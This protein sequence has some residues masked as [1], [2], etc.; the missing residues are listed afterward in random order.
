M[1]QAVGK[2]RAVIQGPAQPVATLVLIHGIGLGPWFWEPWMEKLSERFRVLA[3]SLPGH[4]EPPEDAGLE[5]VIAGV[6]SVLS[7]LPE[8]PILVGH[9]MGAL[10]AQI[11][12]TRH[13]LRGLILMSPLPPGQIFVRPDRNMI[14]HSL[15][16]LPRLPAEEAAAHRSGGLPGLGPESS[17][18]RGGATLVSKNLSLAL[19]AGPRPAAATAGGSHGGALSGFGAAGQRGSAGPVA[20]GEDPRGSLRSRGL[21]LRQPRPLSSAGT[22]WSADAPGSP[23][24]GRKSGTAGGAGE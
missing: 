1:L 11:L 24:L 15:G 12:A 4:G 20:E 17:V 22:R 14:R 21:A 5:E 9:S 18:R 10:V 13:P 19:G 2:L 6:E 8:P 23:R 7:T 3:L 16:L